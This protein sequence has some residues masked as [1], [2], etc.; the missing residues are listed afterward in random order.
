MFNA[1]EGI[2]LGAPPGN[3]F[4]PRMNF[5]VKHIRAQLGDMS[6]PGF[7]AKAGGVRNWI[8]KRKKFQVVCKKDKRFKKFFPCG[9]FIIL[10]L[11]T[12]RLPQKVKIFRACFG[13]RVEF[14]L[15]IH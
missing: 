14:L 5:M 1:R 13:A 6:H 3:F 15:L 4:S 12:I 9:A 10:I 11:L 2:R 8:P 7:A